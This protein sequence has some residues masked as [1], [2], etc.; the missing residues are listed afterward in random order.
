MHINVKKKMH[1]TLQLM[2]HFATQSRG[3]PKDTLHDLHKDA[4]EDAFKIALELH[5]W[6][7][8]LMQSLMHK[9]VQNGSSNIGT[10]AVLEGAK[11]SGLNIG[12]EWGP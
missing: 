1:F 7:H 6:L 10:D 3:A 12:L 8:F 11:D 5:L 2:I 9:C 4:L